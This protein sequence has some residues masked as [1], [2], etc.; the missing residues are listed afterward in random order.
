MIRGHRIARDFMKET[1][2]EKEVFFWHDAD[3]CAS[4]AVGLPQG[5]HR[6][7]RHHLR[8]ERRRRILLDAPLLHLHPRRRAP[9]GRSEYYLHPVRDNAKRNV[10]DRQRDRRALAPAAE[11]EPWCMDSR[12]ETRHHPHVWNVGSCLFVSTSKQT[13]LNLMNIHVGRWDSSYSPR[14]DVCGQLATAAVDLRRILAVAELH[15][16]RVQLVD[17]VTLRHSHLCRRQ[18]APARVARARA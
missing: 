6:L 9:L 1:S 10:H 17:A 2:G 5:Q 15:A 16:R 11:C 13:P 4:R 8:D 18:P 12:K 3:T 14:H 7:Q